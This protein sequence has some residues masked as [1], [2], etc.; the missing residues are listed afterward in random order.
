MTTEEFI[1]YVEERAYPYTFLENGRARLSE[2]H[3]KY[4]E[5]LLLECIDIGIK[6][7]FRYDTEGKL[8][9][10]SVS[11]FLNKLGGI[12]YNKSRSPIDQELYHIKNLCKKT[13]S[14]WN[15]TQGDDILARYVRALRKANWTEDQILDDLQTEV[16]RLCNSSRNWTQWSVK[17]EQWIADIGKWDMPDDA[18]ISESG[19][20]LPVQLFADVPRNIQLICKQINASYE[21]N[22]Y[23][24]TAVM[25]RRLLEGLLVLSYQKHGIE[26]DITEKN[27]CHSTLDRIIKNAAQ[28]GTLALSANTKRDMAL[29]KDI[30]NYSAH[31][32][33]Y[34][35]TKQDIEPHLLKYRVIIE[36]LMYKAGVK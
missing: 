32:I 28:N 1:A 30:G 11:E 25:M 18:S 23:D 24:C 16:I 5:S 19:S 33:W 13:Y 12:A 26:A 20:I 35:S 27:G 2:L 34:N 9:Q 8:S 3:R 10:A 17:M 6:Q 22:L 21:Q 36:E 31:K 15:D 14:Y 4:S 29:F 7:Y